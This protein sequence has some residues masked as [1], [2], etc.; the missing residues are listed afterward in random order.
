MLRETVQLRIS[1]YGKLYDIIVSKEHILRKIKEEIDFSFVNPMLK[2]S[3]CERFG[4]PATEPEVM[5]KILFLKKLYDLSDEALIESIKVNMAYK[6]FLD[7]SPEDGTVDSS[8]LTK[9]RKTRITEDILED[10]L[11]ET[12]TQAITKGLI[13]STAIIV[14]STHSH[15]RYK[16]QSPTEILRKLT[17]ELRMELYRTD[18]ELTEKLPEKPSPFAELNEEIEY[19]KKLVES[20]STGITNHGS[21][22]AKDLL[23]KATE[24]IQNEK[25]RQLQ[26]IADEEARTGHKSADDRFFGYKNHIAMTEERII[27]GI[28]ITDGSADDGKQLASLVQKSKDNG[29]AVS[30]VIGDAAYSHKKNLEYAENNGIKLIAPLHPTISNEHAKDRKGFIFNKDANTYSCPAGHLA[31]SCYKTNG[32]KEGNMV[33][34]YNFSKV[35]CKKCPLQDNCKISKKTRTFSVTLAKDIHKKQL[36][37]QNSDYYKQ[38][39]RQRYKIEA[40]NSEAK[41]YHGLGQADSKGKFAMSL[42]SHFTAFVLNVKRI[43]KLQETIWA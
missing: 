37:F 41:R 14:D 10:M 23:S 16:H 26:S 19:A 25:V 32:K 30:E 3:Y 4:R 17:K 2:S 5:F 15:A 29:I 34:T 22:K 18:Y 27:T 1:E 13:R 36:E 38:R 11:K 7:M 9:F 24:L 42:Q 8:L 39:Y 20:V 12:I 28:E 43:L 31:I 6:Y 35:T 21:A 33:L 40:K